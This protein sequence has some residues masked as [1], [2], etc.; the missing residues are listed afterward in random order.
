M[1]TLDGHISLKT[2]QKNVN[3]FAL[4]L[5]RNFLSHAAGFKH[6]EDQLLAE[7]LNA[8][9]RVLTMFL[10]FFNRFKPSI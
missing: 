4:A 2:C 1:Q 6:F 7:P 10:N 8:L 5:F 9:G 3:L